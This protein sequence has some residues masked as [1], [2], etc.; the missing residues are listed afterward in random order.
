M[1]KKDT[2][3]VEL[4]NRIKVLRQNK[5]LKVREL[6]LLCNIDYSNLSRI[7]NGQKSSRI[8]TLKL[9]AKMLDADIKDIV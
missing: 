7:E 6:G 5:G 3:L 8:L 2:Y 9:I 1:R 4:G